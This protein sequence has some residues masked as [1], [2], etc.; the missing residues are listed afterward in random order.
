VRA[1]PFYSYFFLLG[2][3]PFFEG[4]AVGGLASALDN[5]CSYVA[6]FVAQSLAEI[7]KS[8]CPSTLATQSCNIAKYI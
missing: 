5:P 4:V 3:C 1:K 8:E 6:E 2:T 7:L